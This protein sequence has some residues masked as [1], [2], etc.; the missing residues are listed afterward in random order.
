MFPRVLVA[1]LAGVL[2]AGAF[3]PLSW[4]V[5]MPMAIA[6]FFLTT[7]DL[8]PRRSW[9]PGLVFGAGFCFTLMFWMR[10]VG[11]DAWI[12]LSLLETSFF[13]L[14]GAISPVVTRLK[15]WPLW[16]A[17]AWLGVEVLRSGWPFGGM[18]WGRLAFATPDTPAAPALAYLG[19]NGVS[20]LL[21]LI[22][23]GLAWS[24]VNRTDV[25]RA[26]AV[27]GAPLA[28]LLIPAGVP[29]AAS[30]HDTAQVA[31]VQ[32][33]VP[34][35]GTN[36]LL[37]FRQVT[38]NHVEATQ[39]LADAVAAGKEPRPDFVL[40][41]E[42]STAIDPFA[43]TR[44]NAE[45]DAAVQA[46][47]VPVLVGTMADFGSDHVLNQGVV[48]DPETGGGDRYTK[49]HPVPFGEYIPWRSLFPGNFGKLSMI[50]R[51]M[52]SGTRSTPIDVAGI[53]VA[54]AICFDIAYDDTVYG[55]IE[56]GGEL[57]V[58][59]TSNAM[60]IKTSQIEQQFQISRARAIETGRYVAIA[61]TNGVS[62]IIAPDGDVLARAEPRTQ[63][64]LNVE[65]GLDNSLTPG[66]RIGPWIGRLA[67][68]LTLVALLLGA[69]GYRRR[70]REVEIAPA[71]E[72]QRE[73]V[74]DGV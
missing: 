7:R 4:V 42:N 54:D 56:N 30:P 67:A 59:Q 36:I 46:I 44:I 45:I 60:F 66:I 11:P 15:S 8:S 48:W 39:Q 22:G 57:L 50:P 17:I 31:V 74:R 37:D 13:G 24:A 33:N 14:L 62:G 2:L 35:D 43:D 65:V 53:Q 40:W 32:G 1:G 28:L 19:A 29:Y 5:T 16:A 52:M 34:G 9:L 26:G 23:T 63:A 49:W 73:V 21:A 51:D 38:T 27:V 18:P 10:A 70:T 55:Q 20:L 58:V 3:P 12:A 71:P 68:P 61:S 72:P 47:D 64:V 41:P 69:L 25:M 6:G